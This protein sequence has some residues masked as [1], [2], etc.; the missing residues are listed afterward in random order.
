[1][2]IGIFGLSLACTTL[3]VCSEATSLKHSQNQ[4]SQTKFSQ[5]ESSS[6]PESEMKTM[7][8]K[9]D[10]SMVGPAAQDASTINLVENERN[11]HLLPDP[12]AALLGQGAS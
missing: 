5:V 7:S 6:I 11:M 4:D 2:R 8:P 10:D 9:T 1:M 12:R 3:V